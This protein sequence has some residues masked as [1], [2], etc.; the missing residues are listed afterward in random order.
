MVTKF[1]IRYFAPLH[2]KYPLQAVQTREYGTRGK[3]AGGKTAGAN[4]YQ[5][6]RLKKIKHEL[7]LK[8]GNDRVDFCN[9]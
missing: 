4:W 9:V 3:T 7:D 1:N 5:S 2:K 6:G 8:S